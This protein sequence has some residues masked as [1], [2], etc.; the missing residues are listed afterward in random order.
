MQQLSKNVDL[1]QVE[2]IEVDYVKADDLN[3]IMLHFTRLREMRIFYNSV[4]WLEKNLSLL[5]DIDITLVNCGDMTP[6]NRVILLEQ[7]SCKKLVF[8]NCGLT[9]IYLRN[10]PQLQAVKL[11]DCENAE[12]FDINQ[13]PL[14]DEINISGNCE[15]LTQFNVAPVKQIKVLHMPGCTLSPPKLSQ[16][17]A[18]QWL[19]TKCPLDE[20]TLNIN[21][22]PKL[23]QLDIENNNQIRKINYCDHSCLESVSVNSCG[24]V[25][26]IYI[27]R[28][29][30]L[31]RIDLRGNK[32]CQVITFEN[33]MNLNE[34]HLHDC[35]QVAVFAAKN[36]PHLTH[37]YIELMHGL[38]SLD[39]SQWPELEQLTIKDCTSLREI[40]LIHCRRLRS[41][42]IELTT[43]VKTLILPQS[44][45]LV[46]LVVIDNPQMQIINIEKHPGL[47]NLTLINSHQH[48]TSQLSP[49]LTTVRYLTLSNSEFMVDRNLSN[50]NRVQ[51]LVINEDNKIIIF[52]PPYLPD[53]AELEFANCSR[54]NEFELNNPASLKRLILN[55]NTAL[56]TLT[57]SHMLTL[58]EMEITHCDALTQLNFVNCDRLWVLSITNGFN[59][60][61]FKLL[62][63]PSLIELIIEDC[64]QLTQIDLTNCPNLIK[65]TL[66]RNKNLENLVLPSVDRLEFISVSECA[67]FSYA[68]LSNCKQLKFY[69]EQNNDVGQISHLDKLL[70]LETIALHKNSR[71]IDLHLHDYLHLKMIYIASCRQLTDLK[72]SCLNEL[73][74]LIIVDVNL[75]YID[76][77]RLPKLKK[78]CVISEQSHITIDAN[79]CAEL[80]FVLINAKT[81]KLNIANS[82]KLA[83]LIITADHCDVTDLKDFKDLYYSRNIELDNTLPPTEKMK[84]L[85]RAN[86][87]S[88]VSFFDARSFTTIDANTGM[89]DKVY[90]ADE[91]L[92]P[93][94]VELISGTGLINK[95]LLITNLYDRIIPTDKG[96]LFFL[97]DNENP[98]YLIECYRKLVPFTSD[99]IDFFNS[100][101]K[102]N[103]EMIMGHVS[104]KLK[105]NTL[106]PLPTRYPIECFEQMDIYSV[107][108]DAVQTY[109]HTKHQL[110]Y[111]KVKPH[112]KG[113]VQIL[114]L[115]KKPKIYQTIP[116]GSLLT[117]KPYELLSQEERKLFRDKLINHTLINFIF[118]PAFD[119]D[120]KIKRLLKYFGPTEFKLEDLKSKPASKLD[121]LCDIIIEQKG[122]CRHRARGFMTCAHLIEPNPVPVILNGSER[123]AVSFIPLHIDDKQFLYCADFGGAP[124]LDATPLTMR[125]SILQRTPDESAEKTDTQLPL[126][127]PDQQ[128]EDLFYNEFKRKL[129][130]GQLVSMN[131]IIQDNNRSFIIKCTVQQQPSLVN[132]YILMHLMQRP[133]MRHIY[134][135]RFQEFKQYLKP[136]SIINGVRKRREGP[137]MEMLRCG[138]ILVVN[139]QNFT[140][141]QIVS[142]NNSLKELLNQ[143]PASNI[144]VIGLIN[145]SNRRAIVLLSQYQQWLLHDDFFQQD[146]SLAQNNPVKEDVQTRE[147]DLYERSTWRTVL[148]GKIFKQH[149]T[150]HLVEGELIQAIKASQSL[151][152]FNPPVNNS[153]FELL[154]YR[155]HYERQFLYNGTLIQVPKEFT[156]TEKTRAHVYDLANVEIYSEADYGVKLLQRRLI[157]IGR[158]NLHECFAQF[159]VDQ[160][161]HV[162][163][164]REGGL[165]AQYQQSDVF[166]LTDILKKQD[167]ELLMDHIN[168]TYQDKKFEFVLASGAAIDTIKSNRQRNNCQSVLPEN[169][170]IITSNDPDYFADLLHQQHPDSFMVDV[171]PDMRFNDLFLGVKKAVDDK[172]AAQKD[173]SDVK[174]I[175]T[176]EGDEQAFLY[177]QKSVLSALFDNRRNVV[178]LN[179]VLSATFYQQLLPLLSHDPHV[180]INGERKTIRGRLVVVMPEVAKN[181]LFLSNTVSYHYTFDDYRK[182][183]PVDTDLITRIEQLYLWANK[184]PHVGMGC[185]ESATISFQRLKRMLHDVKSLKLHPHNPIKGVLHYDYQKVKDQENYYYLN[186]LAKYFLRA[187]DVCSPRRD[188]L[189]SIKSQY[190]LNA[191]AD[192]KKCVWRVLNCFSGADINSILGNDL[193]NV[194]EFN[195]L[196][197]VLS[198]SVMIKLFDTINS[199]PQEASN[200]SHKKLHYDKQLQ[201]FHTLLQDKHTPIIIIKGFAGVSKTYTL[202]QLKDDPRY[203]YYEGAENFAAFLLD[204]SHLIKVFGVDEG[205]M[206]KPGSHDFIKGLSR[207]GKTVFYQNKLNVLRNGLHKIVSTGNYESFANRY[208]HSLFQHHGETIIFQTSEDY[209]LENTI[210]APVLQAKN[211]FHKKYTDILLSAYHLFH[212]Y[213]PLF[214]LSIRDLENLARRFVCLIN[215]ESD[216]LAIKRVA[217][218]ACMGEFSGAIVNAEQRQHYLVEISKRVGLSDV[219]VHDYTQTTVIHISDKHAIPQQKHYLVQAIKQDLLIRQK[220]IEA[221]DKV[222]SASYKRCIL[223]QGNTSVGK[224]TLIRD[225]LDGE[226]L[227]YETMS[228]GD[229]DVYARLIKAFHSGTIVWLDKLTLDGINAP[230]KLELLLNKLLTGKDDHDNPPEI[231]GCMVFSELIP[232]DTSLNPAMLNRLH[233]LY[234]DDYTQTELEALAS[235]YVDKPK[236]FVSAFLKLQKESPEC[237]TMGTFFD[238][239]NARAPVVEEQVSR[240]MMP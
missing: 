57:L 149:N 44:S 36:C 222:N 159:I 117:C 92:K 60:K 239:L 33:L 100:L 27:A 238:L 20:K 38:T 177:Q 194:M 232:S 209:F 70:L 162:G 95:D 113:A 5:K 123:H 101:L 158:Y 35:S 87:E 65:L 227:C 224:T 26:E 156:V 98:K 37:L 104:G 185:P 24:N 225:I 90:V 4:R 215:Q 10:C 216:E 132:S 32:Q 76:I 208:F 181:S 107:P 207:D 53:M 221:G 189:L 174:N 77:S 39:F 187:D 81:V 211:L 31:W 234:M 19:H 154:M 125:K 170:N 25:T 180:Y 235:V 74:L 7:L 171:T 88:P 18:L 169:H 118:D 175:L 96:G 110:C 179:G 129:I 78:A 146:E 157:Y 204:D 176:E 85:D 17:T 15:K 142:V 54:L 72:L 112:I 126:L 114:Y 213:N 196:Y 152:I 9:E 42:S 202:R 97:S 120:S 193:Q 219:A 46:R 21:Y 23:Q 50:R 106:Y 41:I 11:V 214:V 240:K 62:W 201:Q 163:E 124:G 111:M 71:I 51:K 217:I 84:Q 237:I 226:G 198:D 210:L 49:L 12:I 186:V 191:A 218:K 64:P 14:L 3:I 143:F 173:S 115:I 233:F 195:S 148:Y 79:D 153:D 47:K 43:S 236:Q 145:V 164:M 103:H 59:A 130:K 172:N 160:L 122:S 52:A 91:M 231:P 229:H 40:N 89:D 128:Q 63:L 13:C 183:L 131:Q 212:H 206:A 223:I 199:I 55:N 6:N 82:I 94:R 140:P 68:S 230:E 109:W 137:L 141:A 188:K 121:E 83:H 45:S 200:Q 147:I 228:L 205:N 30:A 144:K 61:T 29:Q 93:L 105:A 127:T 102:N 197:P 80:R 66:I 73:E 139:W 161:T 135:H 136:W 86:E 203:T 151:T 178:N 56:K 138:G 75:S 182:A 133:E 58:E 34:L 28:C 8:Q 22:W 165:L 168:K 48:I 16:L 67:S 99:D 166:Y 150:T 119:L 192:L 2:E 220:M 108:P 167:W 116:Q 1:T 69:Q 184:L 134:L 155:I 190:K